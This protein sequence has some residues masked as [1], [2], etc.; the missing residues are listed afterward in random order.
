M[1][2]RFSCS[3][4]WGLG[5]LVGALL[6]CG[7]LS[8]IDE[9][10]FKQMAEAE[11]VSALVLQGMIASSHGQYADAIRAYKKANQQGDTLGTAYL[12]A[13]Y[14]SGESGVSGVQPCQAEPLFESVL[15]KDSRVLA[16][17]IAASGIFQLEVAQN[18]PT[19]MPPTKLQMYILQVLNANGAQIAF[20]NGFY[21]KISL[22]GLDK[23]LQE[24]PLRAVYVGACLMA[25]AG[26]EAQKEGDQQAAKTFLQKAAQLDTP[27][28]KAM[29]K[30]MEG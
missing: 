1:V 14:A 11:G 19:S 6:G 8:A 28:A 9:T 5:L 29:L 17:L 2:F 12:G 15:H 20:N 4:Q 7:S 27:G 16:R 10:T 26:I 18:C 3:K 25:L 13:L 24:H 21:R 22:E 23:N 30:Q